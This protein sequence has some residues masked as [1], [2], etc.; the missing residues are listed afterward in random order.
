MVLRKKSRGKGFI[1]A[2]VFTFLFQFMGLTAPQT[3]SAA[4]TELTIT[5]Y[6]VDGTTILEQRFVD[7]HWLMDPNNIDVM[8]DGETRYYHQGPVFKDD[9]NPDEQER[10]R[11]NEEEDQN[12]DT[13]DMGALKGTNVKDLCSLVGGMEN[14]DI[15][16]IKA[17]DG[18]NRDFA[19]KNVYQYDSDREGPMVITWYKDGNYPDTGYTDGMR[20]I[21]FAGA[22]SKTG[23]TS[24]ESLPSG[25]YHVF[26]NWDWHEAADPEY[27]YYWA[28]KGERYP[29]TTGLS[30]YRVTALNIYSNEPAPLD[31]DI[32]CEGTV[33]LNPSETYTINIDSKEYT[34]GQN[35]PLGALHAAS[36]AND[37]TY[38]A[39]DKKWS[40]TGVL[41][42]DNIGPY[43]YQKEGSRWFAYVNG[44]YKDGYDGA[45]YGLNLIELEDQDTVEYYYVDK[46]ID[47]NNLNA[48]KA[49]ATAAVKTVASTSDMDVLFSGTVALDPGDTFTVTIGAN[50][51]TIDQNTPLGALH[52]ASVAKGFTYKASDKKWGDNGILLLD[53]IGDYPYVK[54]GSQW[55]AYVNDVFKDGFAS[56]DDALNVVELFE[57]DR[58]EYYYADVDSDDL[59][60][61][62]AAATAAVKTVAATGVAP[63]EWTLQLTG[64]RDEN[65]TRDYFEEGLLCRE[66]H[67]ASWTDGDG[68]VWG[69]VP[70][71][72]LVGMVDDN[73]DIGNKHFNFND[74]LANQ[75]YEIKII[76]GDGWSTTLSSKDIAHSDAYIIA[77]TLNG[78]TLPLKTAAGKGS[79]PLH[80]KG[81]AI[82][83]GQQ[84]GNIVRIE[85]SGLP[86]PQAGWTL[87]LIGDIGDTITQE[88]FEDGIDCVHNVK[89]TDIEENEWSG[90]P[91]WVLLGAV[92]D[93]EQTGNHWT[94]NADLA[95]DYTVKL[96]AGDGF[97]KTLANAD[98]ANSNDYIV[99]NKYKGE[100]LAGAQAPLRLVG[101]GV[102]KA[103]GSLSGTSVGNLVRIEIPEL[104][105]PEPA[106]GSWNLS[107]KGK[108]TDVMPQAEFEA[109][110]NCPNS[111]HQVEWTDK[112][113]NI[114]SGMP[115][116]LLAGWVDDRKPHGYD[117]VQAVEGYKVIVKASDGYSYDFDSQEINKNSNYIIA[118]KCNGEPLTGKSAP[119]RLVGSGVANADNTLGGKSIGGIAEIKLT[120]F[121]TGGSGVVP[122]LRIVKYGED[123]VTIVDEVTIDY[124]E[125]MER[126]DTIGDGET[127]YK[128]EGVTFKPDDIWG[129]D[130]TYP[131]GFKIAN[132]IKGTK[133]RDLVSLVD[134]MGS[135]TEIDFITKDG[136]V[137]TMPY[138]SIY[139][140]PAVM[141]RQGEAVVAW[142][143]DGKYVPDYKDGMRL[144]FTP[145]DLIYSQ[146]D[147]HE[148]LPEP[149]W[150]YYNDGEVHYPSCAGV[151]PKYITELRVYTVPPGDWTLELDGLELDGLYKEVSKT[152]FESALTCTFGANHKQ[153]YTD[154]KGRVWGGMPLWLLAG[155][156]DDQDLHSN[157]AFNNDLA[158]AGYQVVITSG[159]GKTVT[160]N[161][162]DIIRNN[163]YIIAN[164]LDGVIL[165]DDDTNWPLRLVGPS[166]SGSDSLGN[167]V[168]IKLQNTAGSLTPPALTADSS[169]NRIGREIEITFTDDAAWRAAITNVVVDGLNVAGT[170]YTVAAGKITIADNVFTEAR[171]YNVAV[172]AEG[173]EDAEIQQNIGS[174]RPV[175]IVGPVTDP[176]Y[177]I[178]QT[179]AGIKTMTVNAGI[180]GF[181]YFTVDIEAAA[182]HSG[183]ETA[184]FTHMRNGSQL[185]INS[186]RAD[187]DQVGT[188]QAGFNV[189]AGDVIRVYIVD[190]LT[191]AADHNPVILQ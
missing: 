173:Y 123:G 191:N 64:A 77:N 51:Y 57:E 97:N 65:V 109:G 117:F 75:D 15:L 88:E 59:A 52:A 85:L 36:I 42:L 140:D 190:A 164:T 91:L 156:V 79:W 183:L 143:A 76:A 108:I 153:T 78:E 168:S 17:A 89:W 19:Y 5:K 170:R 157:D 145:E 146:W 177:T 44:V 11:W 10:L 26:G 39:S 98:V 186:T 122:E 13:K 131:G 100:P 92:D 29:T 112:D 185:Q 165:A 33:V 27:W 184:V 34:V 99:A 113:G 116:W 54:K 119:L 87:E 86:E 150:H 35:T 134:G 128:Y 188:A 1:I 7:Y 94:F 12:W 66:T 58:V 40:D 48:V 120:S 174:D 22:T 46:N 6:A 142:Y 139:P 167:I 180:S 105:T 61:V 187:F 118:N 104:Q 136:W 175:Y 103:D 179:L 158:N 90:I 24:I 106:A 189:K 96:V 37:F 28:D 114:W 144:F 14:G 130:Q 81:A 43:P 69:G 176:A 137:T 49:A 171:T 159:D 107:L 74:E 4:T 45:E 73:P 68:N 55:R 93:I 70:L 23:P 62:K 166:V 63:T 31:M 8:G 172:Q 111:G 125:M 162:Q 71:W 82:G 161:S 178:G 47:K 72:L 129:V 135:G 110:V 181:N 124:L 121:A 16:E 182:S 60:A 50:Q 101:A 138:S 18:W 160:I 67:R 163:N 32:L 41:L 38:V 20:L 127:V 56:A 3:A 2:L 53:D 21:W 9:P 115:L 149:Y 95:A 126:F 151:S 147:M 102:T 155:F 154:P 169:D 148:S 141:E 30:G 152:Y 132:A 83:G 84:V 133:V 80:L 25:E